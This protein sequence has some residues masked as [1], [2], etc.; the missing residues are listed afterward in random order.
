[1][2]AEASAADLFWCAIANAI[3]RAKVHKKLPTYIVRDGSGCGS[4]WR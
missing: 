4:G 2:E 1:M 3:N